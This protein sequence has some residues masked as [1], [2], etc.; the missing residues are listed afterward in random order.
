[1][2]SLLCVAREHYLVVF[3]WHC[4]FFPPKMKK[5]SKSV[6]RGTSCTLNSGLGTTRPFENEEARVHSCFRTTPQLD[7]FTMRSVKQALPLL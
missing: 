2:G 5:D 6:G 1:M 4:I 7:G 3:C